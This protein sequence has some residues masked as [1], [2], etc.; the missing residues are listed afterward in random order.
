MQVIYMSGWLGTGLRTALEAS[1][2]V[3]A[4]IEGP[5]YKRGRGLSPV[6]FFFF[7]P[8]SRK[9]TAV[10]TREVFGDYTQ[11]LFPSGNYNG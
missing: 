2:T 8:C 4:S 6:V 9:G 11:V 5:L 7:A 10:E 1:K 3:E